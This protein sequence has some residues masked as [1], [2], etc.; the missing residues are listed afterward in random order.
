MRLGQGSLTSVVFDM[1]GHHD[2]V[3]AMHAMAF[4]MSAQP[5]FATNLLAVLLVGHDACCASHSHPSDRPP[6]QSTHQPTP[7]STRSASKSGTRI[8]PCPPANPNA[9]MSAA[10][11]LAAEAHTPNHAWAPGAGTFAYQVLH[12][13]V[14][15]PHIKLSSRTTHPNHSGTCMLQGI[16]GVE[17]RIPRFVQVLLRQ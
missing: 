3:H 8:A 17:V 5:L 10:A 12:P 2:A 13:H 15:M 16:Q 14:P 11:R 6:S 9:A 4:I 1:Q 7:L